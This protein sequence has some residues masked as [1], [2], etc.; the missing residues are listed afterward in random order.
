MKAAALASILLIAGFAHAQDYPKAEIFGGYS[1]VRVD[2]QELGPLVSSVCSDIDAA[3]PGS[4]PPGSVGINNSFHGWNAAAEVNVNRWLGVKADFSGHYGKLITVS[5]PVQTGIDALGIT[6][7]PPTIRSYNFLFG[8]VFSHRRNNTRAFA[9]ALFGVNKIDTGTIGLSSVGL[10]DVSFSDDAFSMTFGGGVDVRVTDRFNVRLGQ[11]DYVYTGHDF[12]FGAPGV[13]AHQN[14]LRFS[15]GIVIS[16]GAKKAP[17][18]SP[19]QSSPQVV[20]GVEIPSLGAKGVAANRGI[21][22]V[23][24]P[25]GSPAALAGMQPRDVVVAVDD[26][27]VSTPEELQSALVAKTPGS[28]KLTYMIRG[29]WKAEKVIELR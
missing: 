18:A 23:A 21:E 17:E 16:L 14:N 1:H 5:E 3:L 10:P 27:P 7:L 22:L 4:C 8:P 9:H 25:S 28:A 29:M 26:Q 15:A 24:V 6:N 20:P 19:G 2:T 13:A 12:S 11:V